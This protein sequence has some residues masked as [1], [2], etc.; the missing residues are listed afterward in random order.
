MNK[1]F[2][3]TELAKYLGINKRT[4]YNMI[5]DGRMPVDSIKGLQPRRWNVEDID[6]WR[7]GAK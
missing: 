4:V 7:L 3:L 2:S 5:K 1:T 6:A